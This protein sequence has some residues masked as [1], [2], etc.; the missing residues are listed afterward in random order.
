MPFPEGPD[1][2][3]YP[4]ENVLCTRESRHRENVESRD[5]AEVGRIVRNQRQA[6]VSGRCRNPR[7][8]NGNGLPA[9]LATNGSPFPANAKTEWDH[10]I[11]FYSLLQFGQFLLTPPSTV[12]TL[13]KLP[14]GHEGNSESV[15]CKLWTI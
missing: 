9:T 15:S 3:A 1:P 10:Y 8:V 12:R 5:V 13:I 6:M 4:V 2:C 14:D 7:I 11:C